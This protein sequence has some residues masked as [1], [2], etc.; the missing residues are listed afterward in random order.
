MRP[1]RSVEALHGSGRAFA[2]GPTS[3][4]RSL[5]STAAQRHRLVVVLLVARRVGRADHRGTFR[6]RCLS[7]WRAALF[8]CSVTVL[9]LPPLTVTVLLATVFAPFLSFRVTLQ[10]VSVA[11][12]PT[13]KL[14]APFLDACERLRDERHLGRGLV[15]RCDRLLP[16]AAAAAA[17]ATADGAAGDAE[18][19][20][21]GR[22]DVAGLVDRPHGHRVRAGREAGE[23]LRARA[24]GEGA[25]VEAALEAGD[26]AVGARERDAWPWCRSP[27]RRSIA[28]ARRR[29]VDR[30]RRST[31]LSRLGVR[32]MPVSVA[33][34]W[35]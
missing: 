31:T 21:H 12:H 14:T 20:R 29:V 8:S 15:R 1:R 16:P 22:A 5:R 33:R 2:R 13:L 19:P 11:G 35:M 10:L 24:G 4:V 32:R 26:V 9:V 23:R 30:R 28:R 7:C 3:W 34:Y 27:S 17:A 6:L 25:A 18:R